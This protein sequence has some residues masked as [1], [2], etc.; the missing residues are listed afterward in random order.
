[1]LD[2]NT[3]DA[4]V[5]SLDTSTIDLTAGSSAVD[6]S[7][8]FLDTTINGP[9]GTTTP[10]TPPPTAPDNSTSFL[11]R[12]MN[13]ATNIGT[14]LYT[15]AV[16]SGKTAVGNII[17]PGSVKLAAQPTPVKKSNTAM[18]VL[19]GIVAAAGIYLAVKGKK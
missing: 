13:G 18:Y 6:Y 8:T 12:V 7:S 14:Q 19:I 2:T 5:G 15:Q 3:L 10:S 17:A 4:S 1:M 16:T 11:D 9:T